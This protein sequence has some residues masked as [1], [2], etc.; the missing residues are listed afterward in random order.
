L[1]A[2][3][4]DSAPPPLAW[5]SSLVMI[6]E[7]VDHSQH[8]WSTNGRHKRIRM[9]GQGAMLLGHGVLRLGQLLTHCDGVVE[10][11]GLVVDRLA[12]CGTAV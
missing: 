6:T 8:A 10:A 7:P 11:L 12:C 1:V 5:P 3:T 2:A 4:A 9:H